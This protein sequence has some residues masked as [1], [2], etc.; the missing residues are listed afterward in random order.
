MLLLFVLTALQIVK[1]ECWT[2]D[3]ASSFS[4]GDSRASLP[5]ALALK[6][7]FLSRLACF[8]L[9]FPKKQVLFHNLSMALNYYQK[10]Q[11]SFSF[12]SQTLALFLL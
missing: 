2:G 6:L 7:L 1:F 11:F 8:A 5:T 4:R 10:C 9:V 3:S 12:F